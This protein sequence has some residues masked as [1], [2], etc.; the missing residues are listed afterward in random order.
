MNEFPVYVN[1]ERVI[2]GTLFQ[3]I[4]KEITDDL[5]GSGHQLLN[6]VLN[7]VT[8]MRDNFLSIGQFDDYE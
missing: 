8:G 7:S 4:R 5:E 2:R 1:T 6:L 3:M